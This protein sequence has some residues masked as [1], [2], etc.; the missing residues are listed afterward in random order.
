MK[1]ERPFETSLNEYPMTQRHIPEKTESSLP[2]L[3]IDNLMYFRNFFLFKWTKI[4][5][6][7]P[8]SPLSHSK[9]YRNWMN[10]YSRLKCTDCHD[11]PTLQ[12]IFR[13]SLHSCCIS[14]GHKACDMAPDGLHAVC[15]FIQKFVTFTPGSRCHCTH[16]CSELLL[17]LQYCHH[18][19]DHR[20]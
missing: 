9:F 3:L 20:C 14:D 15:V 12:L 16:V 10:P 6:K 2:I 18:Q 17:R 19:A 4:I 8:R 13:F 1:A 11:L 5:I 7:N